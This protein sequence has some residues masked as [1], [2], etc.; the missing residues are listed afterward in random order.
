VAP[1][2]PIAPDEQL[3]ILQALERG[4]IDIDE[5]SERLAG[6]GSNA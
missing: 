5:A 2:A 1:A 3:A 6:R 4:E